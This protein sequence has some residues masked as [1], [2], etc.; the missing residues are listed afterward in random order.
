MAVQQDSR[1]NGGNKPQ[2]QG[3]FRRW[4]GFSESG[5]A[6]DGQVSR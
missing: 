3:P 2:D 4:E 6:E 1:G 5:K